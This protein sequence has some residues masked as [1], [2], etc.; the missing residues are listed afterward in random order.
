MVKRLRLIRHP[1]RI[2]LA[3]SASTRMG[4]P[5]DHRTGRRMNRTLRLLFPRNAKMRAAKRRKNSGGVLKPQFLIL[6]VCLALAS[7]S[8]W[9]ISST[10]IDNKRYNNALSEVPTPAKLHQI[11]AAQRKL[12]IPAPKIWRGSVDPVALPPGV[13]PVIYKIPT[14]KPVVFVT[15]DDGWIQTPENL[16]WLKRHRLPFSLFLTDNGIKNNYGYYKQLQA[17]GMVIEDHTVAHPNLT[18]LNLAQQKAEIC[19]A[20]DTFQTVYGQRPSLFRPPYGSFNSL[21]KEAAGACGMR[22]VVMW[23]SKVDSG[24]VQYQDNNQH[25][26]PGDIVLMHF[27]NDFLHDM[28]AFTEE[29]NT[30]NLYVG[31]LEDWLK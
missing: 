31:R 29:V 10:G 20:A 22:A 15:I 11:A 24:T 8:V 12:S 26:L 17:A 19:S 1:F 18:K 7:L 6:A 28:E 21:T 3:P 14:E 4:T 16:A 23:R 5:K 2:S 13:T 30:Q 25:L 27:K 9:E